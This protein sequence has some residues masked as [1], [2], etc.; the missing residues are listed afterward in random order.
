MAREVAASQPRLVSYTGDISYADGTLSD[1]E[2]FLDNA[3]PVL[4]AMPVIIQEGNHE[5]D[6]C[7]AA[8]AAAAADVTPVYISTPAGGALLWPCPLHAC[9]AGLRCRRGK[10][11][12]SE[13]RTAGVELPLEGCQ[14][15][16]QRPCAD[17]GIPLFLNCSWVNSTI[18]SGDWIRSSNYGF[19]CGY[20]T[21]G[22]RAPA[23]GQLWT[24]PH[25]EHPHTYARV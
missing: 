12:A 20:E 15:C 2:L 16:M 22:A 6:G 14:L 21:A 23:L 13:T 11:S 18:N 8:A 1:W 17:A 3:A 25:P 4:G 7:R 10:L 24:P 5:R 9:Y 19:E